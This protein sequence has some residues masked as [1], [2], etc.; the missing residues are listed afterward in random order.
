MSKGNLIYCINNHGKTKNLIAVVCSSIKNWNNAFLNLSDK[1]TTV[2]IASFNNDVF[3]Y[4]W[5]VNLRHIINNNCVESWGKA[6][7]HTFNLNDD[8]IYI[9]EWIQK[10]LIYEQD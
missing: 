7:I 5:F 6:F 8:L 1:L 10:H 2:D 3:Y 9:N 4:K